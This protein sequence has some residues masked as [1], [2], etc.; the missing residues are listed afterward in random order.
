MPPGRAPTSPPTLTKSEARRIWLRAQRLDTP[1]PFG[2]GPDATR[3]AIEHLGYVQIDT[4][5]VIERAH[6]H[7]LH[8]RIPGYRRDDLRQAQSTDRSVFEYWAHA[9]AYIPTRDYAFFLPAM[10]RHRETLDRWFYSVD[11]ADLRAILARIRDHGPLSIRDIDGDTLVEKTH[12]W[13]S[14]KPSKG[15]LELGFFSGALTISA[16]SGMLKT[17]D[18]TDRHFGWPPRPRAATEPRI[19]AYLLDR[20]LRSQGIVSLDSICYL[21]ARRKS[22]MAALIDDRVRR[23][24][25]LPVVVEDAGKVA[26]WMTPE[27]AQTPIPDQTDSLHILSPFDPLVIQRKRLAFFFGYDHR[28]EAY[29]PKTKRSLGYFALPVLIGDRVVAAID[30]KTD[31]ARRE[32]LIQQWTPLNASA[33]DKPRIEEALGRFEAFQLA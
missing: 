18:L 29:L 7:I 22:A 4:I 30:L 31:R 15:A 23:R 33:D 26:H 14:R 2:N 28:F 12:P 21:D 11:P 1:A 17:Y 24:Q 16:R 8:S 10:K 9:L 13:A 32:L 3:A 20:A 27:T 5:N 6:H 19:L 25:L